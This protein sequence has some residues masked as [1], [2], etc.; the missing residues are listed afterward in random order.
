VSGRGAIT[1]V[2]FLPE[3]R[4]ERDAD[5]LIAEYAQRHGAPVVA[6]VP[7]DDILELHLGLTFAIENLAALFRTDG[8]LGAIWFNE[9]LVRIDTRLD[10]SENPPR[11]GRYRFTLAH[12]IGHWRLHRSYYREDPAQAALF[13]GRGQ[14][15]V[16]CRA[17][18]KKIP[19]EWQADTFAS[20][21]LMPK[22]LVVAAWTEWRG[23]LDPVVLADLPPV[24][25]ANCRDA[26]NATLDRFSKP[27][28]EK[29]EVSAEAM[30]IRL[31]KLGL[32]LRERPN[33]LF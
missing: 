14:P 10:P 12:E 16:V 21:L 27:L 23:N 7:V 30:R 20:Y 24:H 9:K 2:P 8:V 29:F 18:D 25:V 26:A 22:A 33:T 28:A 13:D 4:I 15:A 17:G 31:E 19:V 1:D 11:L 3:V 6:P 32:L 5:V